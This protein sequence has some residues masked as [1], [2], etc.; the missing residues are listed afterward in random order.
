MIGV[1]LRFPSLV[2]LSAAT[3]VRDINFENVVGTKSFRP[4][5]RNEI[6]RSAKAQGNS[7]RRRL[8]VNR[9]IDFRVFRSI[10]PGD[11]ADIRVLHGLRPVPD[12]GHTDRGRRTQRRHILGIQSQPSGHIATVRRHTHEPDQ[13]SG[14]PGRSVGPDSGRLRYR[15]KGKRDVHFC[16]LLVTH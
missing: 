12:R 16:F 5:C 3:T 11:S 4:S 1:D 15:Q 9:V 14:Q 8:N 13:L 10:R 6:V 7:L 2:P